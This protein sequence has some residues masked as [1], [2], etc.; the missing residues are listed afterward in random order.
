[1]PKARANPVSNTVRRSL[2]GQALRRSRRA[3]HRLFGKLVSN[4]G[5]LYTHAN[6]SD[7]GRSSP[8]TVQRI[9]DCF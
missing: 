6:F 1:V 4:L 5:R 3:S 7:A 9:P 2:V 8:H